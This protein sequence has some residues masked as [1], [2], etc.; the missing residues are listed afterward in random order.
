MKKSIAGILVCILC[1]MAS[2]CQSKD[3]QTEKNEVKEGIEAM[4]EDFADFYLPQDHM[5]D[6]YMTALE[7]WKTYVQNPTEGEREK[8]FQ[9]LEE[10]KDAIEKTEC[11][12]YKISD[13]SRKFMVERGISDAE[14]AALASMGES[15]Q[16]EY[17]GQ[18]ERYQNLAEGYKE[19][20]PDQRAMWEPLQ[21]EAEYL[22]EIQKEKNLYM[23]YA[24]NEFFAACKKEELEYLKKEIF[25]NALAF[26][27]DMA[28]W[29]ET[30]QD[31]LQKQEECWTRL[32]NLM[33]EMTR[34][35]GLIMNDAL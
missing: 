21:M 15:D 28:V 3:I 22:Y 34:K 17:L 13:E 7:E 35:T 32:D 9:V 33:E 26:W 14:F 2:G 10:T 16:V 5:A 27:P 11:P 24:T 20:A 31:A 23:Y 12:K 19:I 30:A 4:A 1:I 25:E 8:I 29:Q 6:Q 18:L